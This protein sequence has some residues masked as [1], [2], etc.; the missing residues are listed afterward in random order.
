VQQL[1]RSSFGGREGLTMAT[2]SELKQLE[3]ACEL[4]K[5]VT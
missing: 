4:A 5:L 2:T 1:E 3:I